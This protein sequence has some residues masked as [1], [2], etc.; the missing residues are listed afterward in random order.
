M[1]WCKFVLHSICL[2]TSYF[3]AMHSLA[4]LESITG[5]AL[6]CKMEEFVQ[7][8]LTLNSEINEIFTAR[9]DLL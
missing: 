2:S 1:L 6:N 4:S 9:E 3:D 8:A 5:G 7:S